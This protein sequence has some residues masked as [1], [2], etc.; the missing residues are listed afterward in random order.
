[1]TPYEKRKPN[2]KTYRYLKCSHSSRTTPCTVKDISE[3]LFLDQIKKEVLDNLV[4]DSEILKIY[5]PAIRQAIQLEQTQ[6]KQSIVRLQI[7][8]EELEAELKGYVKS[9]SQGI[10]SKEDFEMMKQDIQEKIANI[11]EQI[12]TANITQ[13]RIDVLLTRIMNLLRNGNKL[14]NSSNVVQK[15]QLLKILLSNCV[16]DGCKLQISLK[17][18]FD[19]LVS[20]GFSHNWQPYS[21][22]NR[23][24]RLERAVS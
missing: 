10:I 2:G 3:N 4:I 12:T 23:D 24:S 21:D 9:V 7:Q 8:K 22:L 18:P 13:D 17:K 16:Y 5:K 14:F 1:M 15:N 11:N 6:S 19:I 20:N